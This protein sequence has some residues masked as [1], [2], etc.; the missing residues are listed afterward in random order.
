RGYS[1]SGSPGIP[2]VRALISPR[3]GSGGGF[4]PVLFSGALLVSAALLFMIEPMIARRILPRF[5]GSP[6]VW[7]TCLAFFQGVLLAGYAYVHLATK[8]LGVRRHLFVHAG[9]I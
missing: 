1:E 6:A 9:L 4:L 2:K 3:F 8:R 7:N 5:G